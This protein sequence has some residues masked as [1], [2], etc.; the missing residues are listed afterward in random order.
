MVATRKKLVTG[1][2][3]D[4]EYTIN[5]EPLTWLNYIFVVEL[6][7]DLDISNQKLA[8]KMKAQTRKIFNQGKLAHWSGNLNLNPSG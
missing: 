5:Q 2:L 6:R 8:L 7:L 4:D 3:M 1:P